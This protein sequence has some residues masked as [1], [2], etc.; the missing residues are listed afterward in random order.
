MTK[1]TWIINLKIID[2]QYRFCQIISD[3]FNSCCYDYARIWEWSINK[4]ESWIENGN[5]INK[6]SMS[7]DVNVD[8]AWS[9]WKRINEH[10]IDKSVYK[11]I[12]LSLPYL[13]E[14]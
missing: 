6:T 7:A 4:K 3:K 10:S 8:V 11:L 9:W 12:I 14:K 13:A 5:Q 1:N 2:I